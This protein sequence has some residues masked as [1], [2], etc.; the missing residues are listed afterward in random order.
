MVP[1]GL[2]ELIDAAAGTPITLYLRSPNR[3]VRLT[4]AGPI[5]QSG[6]K[7]LA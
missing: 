3:P 2:T 7:L 4:S 6:D 1:V 5:L